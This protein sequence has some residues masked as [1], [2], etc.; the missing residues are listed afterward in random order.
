MPSWEELPQTPAVA[1]RKLG[2]IESVKNNEFPRIKAEGAT[3]RD[4]R[5]YTFKLVSST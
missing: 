1:S 5:E 2:A 4:A 3:R